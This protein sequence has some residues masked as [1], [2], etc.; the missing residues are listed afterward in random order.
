VLSI[1]RSA[2]RIL[3]R[4][5]V[6]LLPMVCAGCQHGAPTIFDPMKRSLARRNLERASRHYAAG[7]TDAAEEAFRKAIAQNPRDAVAHAMLGDLLRARGDLHGAADC[8]SSAVKNDP[9]DFDYAIALA[10]TLYAIA[11]TADHSH[12]AYALATRAYRNARILRDDDDHAALGLARCLNLRGEHAEARDLLLP[13]VSAGM[14]GVDV[15]MELARAFLSLGDA[16]QA[17][18]LYHAALKD[19]DENAAAHWGCAQACLQ[20]CRA[21]DENNMAGSSTSTS[22]PL[23]TAAVAFLRERAKAHLR[24]VIE[25][26]PGNT[27][28]HI[29]LRELGGDEVLAGHPDEIE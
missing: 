8:Y 9:S 18:A 6:G 15:V 21:A 2:R 1:S 11:G 23:E 19:D 14:G 28:A 22:L 17:L 13:F 25:L 10:D 5:A 16:E 12:R 20:K 7:E 29:S 26:N 3:S 24:R 4:T 27:H